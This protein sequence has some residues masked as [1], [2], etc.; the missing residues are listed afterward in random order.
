MS[1][2]HEELNLELSGKV[3][4]SDNQTSRASSWTLQ[5][6]EPAGQGRSPATKEPGDQ[7]KKAKAEQ[8]GASQG[9]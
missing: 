4:A 7:H 9:R 3:K 5:T 6:G 2:S 1:T 8:Q